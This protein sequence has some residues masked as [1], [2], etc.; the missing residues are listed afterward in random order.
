MLTMPYE[1]RSNC[2]PSLFACQSPSTYCHGSISSYLWAI[3]EGCNTLFTEILLKFPNAFLKMS[4]LWD[5][6][7]C[8]QEKTIRGTTNWTSMRNPAWKVQVPLLE[9]NVMCLCCHLLV[10][11][12][13]HTAASICQLGFPLL[14]LELHL[15][16]QWALKK[17]LKH[18]SQP[19]PH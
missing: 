11:H 4:Y 14:T 8:L 19:L 10:N 5:N 17:I 13:A 6:L 18:K 15:Q 7:W 9:T 2:L 12:P 3:V 1:K 16:S